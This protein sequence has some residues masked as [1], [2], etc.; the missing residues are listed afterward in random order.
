MLSVSS[1]S[2]AGSSA[3]SEI[4]TFRAPGPRA[5]A[6]RRIRRGAPPRRSRHS[7]ATH[8]RRVTRVCPRCDLADGASAQRQTKPRWAGLLRSRR[9]DSN[10]GP[11]H[12]EFTSGR[13]RIPRFCRETGS[14]ARHRRSLARPR[15]PC[16]SRDVFQRCSNSVVAGR[17]SR[18]ER[19]PARRSRTR[20]P[21]RRSPR[22]L[23]GWARNVRRST[24]GERCL[25]LELRTWR[26]VGE[27]SWR[28]SGRSCEPRR[29]TQVSRAPVYSEAGPGSI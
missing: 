21:R 16:F 28:S 3:R 14:W 12:Y 24:L 2:R 8:A 4:P 7:S 13:S 17:R 1:A 9:A 19:R 25:L 20:S 6:D 22:T 18:I 27:L 29:T 5:R 10:R 23:A 15:T 11:L 26:L